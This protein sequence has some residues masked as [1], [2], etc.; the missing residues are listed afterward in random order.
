MLDKWAARGARGVYSACFIISFLWDYFFAKCLAQDFSNDFSN[1]RTTSRKLCALKHACKHQVRCHAQ[2]MPEVQLGIATSLREKKMHILVGSRSPMIFFTE[3]H[4]FKLRED[5]RACTTHMFR[6]LTLGIC[7]FLVATRF[8]TV[9]VRRRGRLLTLEHLH[10]AR[11]T[12]LKSNNE[13]CGAITASGLYPWSRIPS[14]LLNGTFARC[15]AQKKISA[16][17]FAM[18]F[19]RELLSNNAFPGRQRTGT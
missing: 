11:Q 14:L 8:S 13:N 16:L 15:L 5:P 17:S 1:E 19:E 9:Y 10:L 3:S 7:A 2:E 6:R 18:S 12:A 4:E